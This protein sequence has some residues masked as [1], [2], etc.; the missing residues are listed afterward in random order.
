M[1]LWARC[2]RIIVRLGPARDHIREH[3][4]SRPHVCDGQG[5][6]GCGKAFLRMDGL[7]RH[8]SHCSVYVTLFNRTCDMNTANLGFFVLFYFV[9][10]F[11]ERT[12]PTTMSCSRDSTGH[13]WR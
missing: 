13:E 1:C 11:P 9:T 3:C 7:K 5:T 2:G 8:Q 10:Q 12:R 4:E 6:W